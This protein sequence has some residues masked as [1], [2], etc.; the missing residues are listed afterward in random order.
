[1]AAINRS[2]SHPSSVPHARVVLPCHAMPW[3]VRARRDESAALT[4]IECALLPHAGG[5]GV[6]LHSRSPSARSLRWLAALQLVALG[7]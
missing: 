6:L 2:H 4:A 1:M 5:G 7:A 3:S